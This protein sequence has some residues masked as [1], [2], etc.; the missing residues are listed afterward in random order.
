MSWDL[1][2]VDP[3]WFVLCLDERVCKF[4]CKLNHHD[5]N[6]YMYL[7]LEV[8]FSMLTQVIFMI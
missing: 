8:F 7:N 3:L 6:G 2:S 1:D 4:L 5:S